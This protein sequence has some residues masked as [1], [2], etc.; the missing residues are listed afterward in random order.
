MYK[1]FIKPLLSALSVEQIHNIIVWVLRIFGAI[2][3]ARTL[4]KI[5]HR[6][7]SESLEREV[8]GLKFKNPI[9]LAPGFD[10]NAD[11]IN[12]VGSLGFGF[13][14]VGAITPNPQIGNPKPRLFTLEE[15]SAL[16]S[17]MGQPNKGLKYAIN[18]LRKSRQSEIIVGCNIARNSYS[19][20]AEHPKEYLSVFRN[21]YQYVDYFTVNVISSNSATDGVVFDE[22]A[23]RKI[24]EPLFEFRRGQSDYRPILVKISPDLSDEQIDVVTDIMIDTPLDGLVAVSGTLRRD[25]LKSSGVSVARIGSGRMSGAP[26]HARALEVV[27]RVYTRSQGAYPI[28]GVGGV[29][30]PEDARAML[31]AGASLVQIYSGF[32]YEG[33]RLVKDIC[34][35]LIKE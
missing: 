28:I 23:L 31:D 14:E 21:L 9:G 2:P 7:E 13:V 30:S 17:R 1:K 11:I 35:S 5:R 22:E 34:K 29:M 25:D 8:F 18:N 19:P 24:I 20:A 6:V 15:D 4:L 10:A 3:G 27:K 16:V 12:E 33:A 26:I 32:V